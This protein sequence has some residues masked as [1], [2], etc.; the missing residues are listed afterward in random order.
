MRI[1]II[2]GTESGESELVA[3]DIADQ[4]ADRHEVTVEN[5]EDVDVDAIDT[6]AVYL[7]VCS[8]HGEGELPLSARPFHAAL[9]ARR[10][11][12][13]ALRYAVLGRGDRTYA[14]TYSRGSEHIDEL[15][16]ELGA[17]RVGEYGR[18]DASDWNAPEDL[19]VRWAKGVVE[20]LESRAV[21]S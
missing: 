6:E 3:E 10:P 4:L 1:S 19:A 17:T 13:S 8:T 15:L 5:M 12:L 14:D 16:T 21:A 9:S 2:Y 7:I 18:E 20:V 11:D